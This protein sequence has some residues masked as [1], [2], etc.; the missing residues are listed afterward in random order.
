MGSGKS[1]RNPKFEFRNQKGL[2][3]DARLGWRGGNC[4]CG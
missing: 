2:V 4:E 3:R 1:G